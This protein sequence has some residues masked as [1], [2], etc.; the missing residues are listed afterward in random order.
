MATTTGFEVTA[1]AAAARAA[2]RR[3]GSLTSAQKDAALLAVAEALVAEQ[4]RLV[5][6][7]SRKS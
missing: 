2:S 3:M 1:K 5:A 6:A 7:R 4:S